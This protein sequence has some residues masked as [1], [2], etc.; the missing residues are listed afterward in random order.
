MYGVEAAAEKA[1][2]H[3]AFPARFFPPDLL[4]PVLPDFHYNAPLVSP[5]ARHCCKARCKSCCSIMFPT[6]LFAPASFAENGICI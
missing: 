5:F 2:I 6:R 1:D 4:L 3:S